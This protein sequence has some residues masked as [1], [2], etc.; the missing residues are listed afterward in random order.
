MSAKLSAMS[1]ESS[2]QSPADAAWIVGSI[3]LW[4]CAAVYTAAWLSGFPEDIS[5]SGLLPYA[6]P[7][8]IL[9]AVG[10]RYRS[11]KQIAPYLE[12]AGYI[13]LSL[14]HI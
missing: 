1:N 6:I 11:N 9:S 2:L 5:A 3:L 14:I 8:V 13:F 7:G 10:W 12:P 4:G